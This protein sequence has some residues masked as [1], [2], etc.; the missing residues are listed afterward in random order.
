[1]QFNPVRATPVPLPKGAAFVVAHSL[2]SSEKAGELAAGRYNLRVVE[3]RLAAVVLA[4]K[5]EYP[6]EQ[7]RQLRT[8]Q[9]GCFQLLP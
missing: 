9:V 2:A 3:C 7:A 8:L 4:I 5:L 6:V 1:V